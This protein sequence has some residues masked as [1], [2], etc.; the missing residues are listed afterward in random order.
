MTILCIIPGP[1]HE[2]SRKPDTRPT[3]WCFGCRK[4][5]PHEIVVIGDP[6]GVISYYEH[7]AIRQCTRC[8]H[9]RTT[10]PGCDAA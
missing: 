9:D 4:H 2:Y 1:S 6:P 5:L 8:R 10:F 3:R 7:I